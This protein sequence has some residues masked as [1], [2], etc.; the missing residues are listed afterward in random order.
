MAEPVRPRWWSH[1]LA[2]AWYVV[3]VVQSW[4]D[5]AWPPLYQLVSAVGF[6]VGV[7]VLVDLGVRAIRSWR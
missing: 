1:P 4:W 6:G 7:A 2:G 5:D 3:I